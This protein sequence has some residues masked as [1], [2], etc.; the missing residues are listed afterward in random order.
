MPAGQRQP[1]S[2]KLKKPCAFSEP[3]FLFVV[4]SVHDDAFP[5]ARGPQIQ[6]AGIERADAAALVIG[7][8][9]RPCKRPVQVLFLTLSG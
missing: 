3:A 8:G 9:R 6:F 4:A 5:P 2:F 1:A 7:D